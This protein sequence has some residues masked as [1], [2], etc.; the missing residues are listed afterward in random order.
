MVR[1]GSARPEAVGRSAGFLRLITSEIPLTLTVL[2]FLT[3][4]RTLS[5]VDGP[6]KAAA[7]ERER[8]QAQG[9]EE[10][11]G[12]REDAR[13][14]M[15]RSGGSGDSKEGRLRQRSLSRDPYNGEGTLTPTNC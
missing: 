7:T 15:H 12:S 14:E 9:G 4:A 13:Q 10:L 5:G 2:S 8:A 6:E 3:H 11:Q 1:A